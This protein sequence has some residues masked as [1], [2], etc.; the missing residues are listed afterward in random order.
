MCQY[1]ED[2]PPHLYCDR[3]NR[4]CMNPCTEDY[5][6]DNAECF[7]E[8]HSPQCRCLPNYHGNAF[9]QCLRSESCSNDNQCPPSQTCVNG[10]CVEPIC[11][12]GTNAKCSIES[13][14]PIC[15][16]PKGYRG[17]PYVSCN[18]NLNP[19]VPSPC[20]KDALC[21]LDGGN[22]ICYCPKNMT[23][24]PFEKCIPQ[25]KECTRNTCGPNSICRM[26]NG[27]VFCA[28]SPSYEGNPPRKPCK[29]PKNPCDSN[30]CGPNTQ[31][32]I[33]GHGF[34]K[35]S[36]LPGFIEST[37]TI[38]GCVESKDP[39]ES[40]PCGVGAICDSNRTPM[41][42]CPSHT[43]GNPFRECA[44]P[45]VAPELC[46]SGRC[47]INANC[48]VTSND[49]ERCECL[50]G[51]IGDPYTSCNEVP[52]SVCDPNPCGPGAQCILSFDGKSMCI[53][54]EGTHGDP[55]SLDGCYASEC[56][57]DRDCSNDKACFGRTCKNPC[58]GA[59]GYNTHCIVERHRPGN[60]R[61][62]DNLNLDLTFYFFLL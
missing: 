29:L 40:N 26:T 53:C 41:C 5:C 44:E 58:D 31:C 42:Y 15:T 8:N 60:I 61:Y 14:K 20:G 1:N 6:G 2:C 22:P 55:T 12:C 4:A 46:R 25:G 49:Q 34:A 24:N 52:K 10:Q 33:E 48:F 37:N 38:R 50:S 30:V 32:S 59:C 28:C 3:L 35:C 39:C 9:I 19:C 11:N 51:Y 16:C 57:T 62:F 36:C 47:G 45:S 7:V 13:R 18:L 27:K 43:R 23:G 17:D 21:E 54:P 56:L